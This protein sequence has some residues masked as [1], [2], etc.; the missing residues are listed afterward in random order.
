[1]T[2]VRP[3]DARMTDV[4]L[5]AT[6]LDGTLLRGDSTLSERTVRALR[7][8]RAMGVRVVLATARPARIV[9]DLFADQDLL[10]AAICGNGAGRLDLS[11]RQH[12]LTHPLAPPVVTFVMAEIERLVPGSVF[13][14]ETGVRVLHEPEYRYRPSLDSQRFPVRSRAELVAE[15]VAKVLVLLPHDDAASAWTVLRPTLAP[16]VTCTWSAGRGRADRN[17]PAILEIAAPGVSKGA[18]LAELCTQWGIE[19]AQVVAFGDAR[20]DLDMLTW[21]GRGYA[22]ANAHPEVLAA[23]RHHAPANDEDGVAQVLERLQKARAQP[24]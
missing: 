6:D 9:C 10:D 7:M 3:T 21:A 19:P 8:V 12:T 20:N 15:P 14:V 16:V 22:V 4:R 13:A 2:D 18:A 11:T 17:Y 24:R 5:V 1:M 23:A